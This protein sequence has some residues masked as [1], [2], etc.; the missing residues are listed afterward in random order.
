MKEVIAYVHTHWDREWYREFQEFRLR[1]VE[2][3]ERVLAELQKNEL[4][5]FYFDGQTGAI[6][7]YLELYP[8]KEAIVKK[9]ISEKKL[10]VGPFYCLSDVFL[11]NLECLIRNLIYGMKKSKELGCSEFIAYLADTFGHSKGIISILNAFDIENIMLWRGLG[12]LPSEFKWQNLNAV[13]LIQGYFQDIFSSKRLSFE[14]KADN[15][16]ILLDKI[17]KNSSKYILLP[18]GAD[19]LAPPC[20]LSSQIK[21]INKLLNGYKIRVGT[22]FEYFEKVKNNHKKIFECEFLDNSKTFLLKGVYS[23]RIYLKQKNAI[24]QWKLTRLAEPL[25]VFTNLLKFSKSYQNECDYAYKLLIK[26]HAHDSIY[27]CSIDKVHQEMSTRYE[28]VRSLTNGIIKR[29]VR[30]FSKSKDGFSVINLSNFDYNGSV[31][32]I[33]DKCLPSKMNAQLLQT[34][35]N[36]TDKKLYDI[37]EIP[38]TED[39]TN[40]YEYLIDV[41]NLRPFSITE[42]DKM[43]IQNAKTLKI[44]KN[45]IENE[46]IG[47]FIKNSEINLID[48]KNKKEYKNFLEI[49]DRADIGDSYNFGALKNDKLLKAR[50]INSKILTSGDVQAILRLK[51]EIKIPKKATINGRSKVLVSHKFVVD[52]ILDNQDKFLEFE[53]NWENKST[54]HL[55]QI[56]FNLPEL[57]TKTVSEDTVGLME[58]NI[59]ADYDIYAAIPAQRGVEL[60]YN[61]FP[62]QRFVFAQNI[63]I[64]TKGLQE[65]EVYKNNLRLTILRATGV[66]SNPKNPTRGT[67]AGPPLPTPELQCMAKNTAN[68][69]ISFPDKADD[70]Y[71]TVEYFYNPCVAIF[72]AQNFE[73]LPFKNSSEILVQSIK[74]DDKRENIIARVVNISDKP[75]KICVNANKG[76]QIERISPLGEKIKNI[77]NFLEVK[78]N[79]IVTLKCSKTID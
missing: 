66:I 23:S 40:I 50:F 54:D 20:N 51:F 65:Y 77:E 4:K 32:I 55:L 10:F 67:P 30:D 79:E 19:H 45:S 28:S 26:N 48:K 11:V 56:S 31:K 21:E 43:H 16:Q 72:S 64:T 37:D 42:I 36:F 17:A 38:V 2:V 71:K 47:L 9:L 14:Q 41:K 3:F 35:K 60:K 1:L 34:E 24:T 74:F 39:Y 69:T 27:G 49:I 68:F 53:I 76:F 61:I 5:S 33:T 18:I 7:D 29:C 15:L 44:T 78:S 13:N 70:L 75:Q 8:E 12:D 62:M 22:P 52:V 63:G 58:R 57:I 73:F 46:N 59:D 25:Q 6:E